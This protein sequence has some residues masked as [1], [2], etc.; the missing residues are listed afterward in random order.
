MRDRCSIH[1][2]LLEQ[3]HGSWR[4]QTHGRYHQFASGHRRQASHARTE[5]ILSLNYFLC[6]ILLSIIN[7]RSRSGILGVSLQGD[8]SINWFYDLRCLPRMSRAGLSLVLFT[9]EQFPP[10]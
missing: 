8:R 1:V 2:L 6:G 4:R 5:L 10:R 3:L 7:R 9:K